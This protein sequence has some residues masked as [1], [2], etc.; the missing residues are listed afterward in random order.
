MG[1]VATSRDHADRA[2]VMKSESLFWAEMQRPDGTR[3]R[4]ETS[5]HRSLVFEIRY[6]AAIE[7]ARLLTRGP[8][9]QNVVHCT[10]CYDLFTQ[11]VRRHSTQD[12]RRHSTVCEE[13]SED[14]DLDLEE[15]A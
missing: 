1:A 7:N 12:V 6:F 13:C 4:I 9:P 5:S 15:F 3:I 14:S 8:L 2:T 11:D 10:R